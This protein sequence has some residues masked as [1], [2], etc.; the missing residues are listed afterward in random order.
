MRKAK[1]SGRRFS[2][3]KPS[4]V[5]RPLPPLPPPDIEADDDNA[6]PSPVLSGD[7]L[8]MPADSDIPPHVWHLLQQAGELAATR[9]VGLLQS[10]RFASYAPTAQKALIELALTRA[11]GLPIRRA[12][13]VNLSSTDADAVAASLNDLASAL[14]EHARSA[15]QR[16]ASAGVRVSD[17]GEIPDNA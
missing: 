15:A 13:N 6:A 1:I 2:T 3:P 12:L 16:A 5:P 11:Y 7:V 8:P 10:P 9:L 14:P 4:P 17:G